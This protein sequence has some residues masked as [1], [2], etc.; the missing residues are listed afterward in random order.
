MK[1]KLTKR[2]AGGQIQAGKRERGRTRKL[3]YISVH[4]LGSLTI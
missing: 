3:M 4:T 2:Q 1:E